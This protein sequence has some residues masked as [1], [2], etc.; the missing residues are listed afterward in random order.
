V[1]ILALSV[2][3]PASESFWAQGVRRCVQDG[4]VAV[5]VLALSR[6]GGPPNAQ[7]DADM[8]AAV[9][10][11]R[12]RDVNVVVAAGNRGGSAEWP[13]TVPGALAVGGVDDLA[14]DVCG[15]SA[16]I[17]AD[18]FAAG[19]GE[20]HFQGTSPAAARVGAVLAA[21]RAFG[22]KSAAAAETALLAGTTRG[23]DGQ[24][25]MSASG[26]FRR[27]G[28]GLL[29]PPDGAQFRPARARGRDAFAA[30]D[31]A[32]AAEPPARRGRARAL[33]ATRAS[34]ASGP[35]DAQ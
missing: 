19:C 29:T 27:A 17:G 21:L 1:R 33:R 23:A 3:A 31:R 32:A 20:Q 18:V 9:A 35:V 13:S 16:V 5:I 25:R 4:R 28:L 12:E 22:G 34:H 14:G 8:Q 11:A 15:F 10:E 6:P 30:A 7:V 24:P 26:A 2:G